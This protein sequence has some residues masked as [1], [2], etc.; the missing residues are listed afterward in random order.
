MRLGKALA[1]GIAEEDPQERLRQTDREQH[2][3]AGPELEP[4]VT[5]EE[6]AA[7]VPAAR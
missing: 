3:E 7:G 5:A 6:P 4:A 1:T 2:T